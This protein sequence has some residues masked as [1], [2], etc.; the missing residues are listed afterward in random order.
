MTYQIQ[1]R[2]LGTQQWEGYF[3]AETQAEIASL[4]S[5]LE[6]YELKIQ[7]VGHAIE[8]IH[9]PNKGSII[10]KVLV[11]ANC[12]APMDC[13]SS[14]KVYSQD[15]LCDA[16]ATEKII[17]WTFEQL[18]P[19][20]EVRSICVSEARNANHNFRYTVTFGNKY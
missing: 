9:H 5:Q 6:G 7:T 3:K 20:Y 12:V 2:K 17:R 18:I 11:S 15:Y 14:F 19:C 8:T 16:N 1:A 10:Q 4:A 13:P